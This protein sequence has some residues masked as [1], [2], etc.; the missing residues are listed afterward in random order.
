MWEAVELREIRVFLTLADE[1]HFGRSAERLGLTT[2]RVSQSLRAL[3]HKLGGPL[4]HRTSRHVA[5]TPLGERYRHRLEAAHD[6]LTRVLEDIHTANKA[7]DGVLRLG[8]LYPTAGGPG[9]NTIVSAFEQRHPGCEVQLSEVLLDDPLGPLRRG[10]ID[11][12]ATRL[13]IDQADLV[14][15]PTLSREPR[16]LQVAR[17]HPLA[18]RPDVSIEHLADYHVAPLRGFPTETVDAL[19]PQV[20]PTGRPIRRRH[21]R[22]R[23]R[24]PYDV[25]ALIARGTIVHPTVAS[26][27]DYFGHPDIVHIPINDMPPA[28]TGLVWQRPDT[29]PRIQAFIDIARQILPPGDTGAPQHDRRR[30]SVSAHLSPVIGN[31]QP[32]G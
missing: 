30:S 1:L 22:Q 23:L 8:L 19:I 21:L 26:Y 10:E 3:E 9:L 20:T 24:T 14:V 6:Q 32:T 18:A 4:V 2:S 11:L 5:L 25:E 16:V 29:D 13:P 17:T 12:M 28:E 31:G 7:I 15:G 27:A